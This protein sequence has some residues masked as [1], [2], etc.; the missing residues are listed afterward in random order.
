M[1]TGVA[2]VET[3]VAFLRKIEAKLPY[4]PAIPFLEIDPKVFNSN[5]KDPSTS[6]FVDVLFIIA[7]AR[8]R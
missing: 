8:K 2:T 4:N 5:Y 6:M 1:Q 3:T 7:R